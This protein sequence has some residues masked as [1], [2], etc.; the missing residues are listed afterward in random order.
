M[1]HSIILK[2]NVD[3]VNLSLLK[4][5][6]GLVIHAGF[7]VV[8]HLPEHNRKETKHENV[9][10]GEAISVFIVIKLFHPLFQDI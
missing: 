8:K 5:S 1:N 2:Q 6:H 3:S 7:V 4:M 10:L 9:Y